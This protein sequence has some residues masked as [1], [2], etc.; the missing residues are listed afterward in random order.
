M[1]RPAE[2]QPSLQVLPGQQASP[3]APQRAH[4]AVAPV[5]LQASPVWHCGLAPPTGQ[6]SSPGPPH[7]AQV[8][9]MHINLS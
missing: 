8:L 5:P 3:R 2:Q 9:P 6:Q 4:T 1:H 7:E